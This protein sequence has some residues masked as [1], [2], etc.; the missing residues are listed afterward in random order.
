MVTAAYDIIWMQ[1]VLHLILCLMSWNAGS[2]YT[3]A[4]LTAAAKE[5]QDM[6]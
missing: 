5:L 4:S 1:Q 3:A 2:L 6:H